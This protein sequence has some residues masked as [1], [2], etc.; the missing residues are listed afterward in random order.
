VVLVKKAY[1]KGLLY[2]VLPMTDKF[3]YYT[4]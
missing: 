4:Y 3:Q 2:T 1:L